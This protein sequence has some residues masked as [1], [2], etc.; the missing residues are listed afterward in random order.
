MFNIRRIEI[1]TLNAVIILWLLK[2]MYFDKSSDVFGMFSVLTI[3]FLIFLNGY[4][5]FVDK[6][7]PKVKKNKIIFE[8]L[9]FA[10]LILPLIILWYYT[11]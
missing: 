2:V 1:L 8:V 10:A 5:I 4:F 9:F 11:S 6:F 3:I 7:F